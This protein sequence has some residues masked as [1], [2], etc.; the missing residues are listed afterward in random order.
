M[1]QD[2]TRSWFAVLNNPQ[3]HG[4]EG[5]PEQI[6][7]RLKDEWIR[8]STTRS[9]A[10]AYCISADGLRHIHM[11]LEDA[12]AMRFSAVKK[13]YAI[14]CH[15]EAT[16]GT[17]KQAE[18]YIMKRHPYAEKGEEV[19]CIVRTG[20]ILGAPGKRTDI[21]A[22]GA[23][24]EDGLTPHEIM[25]GNF[26]FRRYEREIKSAYFRRL[27]KET[28]PVR[29]VAVHLLV[30]PSGSGKTHKY[31]ELCDDVGEDNVCLVTDYSINGGLDHYAGESILFLDEFK[32][33]YPYS[34]FLTLTD[35]YKAQV[36]ARYTNIWCLWSEVY[37]T[38]VFPP[39]DLYILMVP[40]ERRGLDS[41]E[42]MYRR[43]SDVTYC[44]VSESGEYKRFTLPMEQYVN[45]ETF[46]K[47]ATSEIPPLFQF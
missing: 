21:E 6:C 44:Y 16:K 26:S 47:K 3:D 19:V 17:K 35:R 4:Y 36:H 13:S 9:G 38:S 31:V 29:D 42:Q 27:W 40:S 24:I 43:I 14:G 15:L 45:F 34:T 10:W 37:I 18:D 41:R 20:T 8:D 1:A 39:E 25:D 28:P 2:V 11:V 33:Q 32:G 46:V 23:L 5:T 22:I 12:V 7:E 30:G